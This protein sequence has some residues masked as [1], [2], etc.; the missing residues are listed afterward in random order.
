MHE[1]PPGPYPERLKWH[2]LADV[3]LASRGAQ[4]S[5][6]LPRQLLK[7]VRI[8]GYPVPSW[9]WSRSMRGYS[10]RGA[11]MLD[12]CGADSL[13]VLA[14]TPAGRWPGIALRIRMSPLSERHLISTAASAS[15]P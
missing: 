5:P 4:L 3:L 9:S 15:S 10:L 6:S 7:Q 2:A 8:H 13:A 14:T 11:E 1:R 12:S